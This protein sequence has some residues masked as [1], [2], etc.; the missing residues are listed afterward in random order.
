MKTSCGGGD[1]VDQGGQRHGQGGEGLDLSPHGGGV[2]H[3]PPES[4]SHSLLGV[5]NLHGPDN[6][7]DVE[8]AAG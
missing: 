4:A 6:I 5:E 2:G 7:Q 1:G 3:S 8:E